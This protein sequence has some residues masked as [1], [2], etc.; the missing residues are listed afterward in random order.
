MC[1]FSCLFVIN[2]LN[3]EVHNVTSYLL[4]CERFGKM[5]F[6]DMIFALYVEFVIQCGQ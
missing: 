5:L 1:Y 2:E 4:K 6:V 3:Y